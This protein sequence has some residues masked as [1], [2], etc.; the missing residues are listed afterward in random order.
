MN[1]KIL[2]LILFL[3]TISCKNKVSSNLSVSDVRSLVEKDTLYKSLI[4]K[5]QK[6]QDDI[7]K[8]IILNAKFYDL[9]YEQCL[10]YEKKE[11]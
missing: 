9:T 3:F 8:D 5:I 11:K 7:S 6:I 2:I 10:N 1:I 4:P